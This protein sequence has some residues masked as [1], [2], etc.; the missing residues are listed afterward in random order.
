MNIPVGPPSLPPPSHRKGILDDPLPVLN[1]VIEAPVLPNQSKIDAARL[2]VIRRIKMNKHKL[3]KLR[4]RMKY[5]WE[6]IRLRRATWR[7]KMFLNEKMAQVKAAWKFDAKSHVAQL[8]RN[9]RDNQAPHPWIRK[10]M[11]DA[12]IKEQIKIREEKKRQ[13]FLS[14]LDKRL[15]PTKV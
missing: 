13:E 9:V 1:R 11:P 14:I 4:K 3:K 5:V 10:G 12:F 7:E 15:P 2:V 6:K 8:I